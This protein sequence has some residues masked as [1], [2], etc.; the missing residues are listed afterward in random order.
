MIRNSLHVQVRLSKAMALFAN[1]HD[2]S[3]CALILGITALNSR[4][5]RVIFGFRNFVLLLYPS[6]FPYEVM[7]PSACTFGTY[8]REYPK[9]Q[10][11]Y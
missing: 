7:Q 2:S 9:M 1:I 10:R 5:I 11:V 3:C 8:G 6:W 4:R